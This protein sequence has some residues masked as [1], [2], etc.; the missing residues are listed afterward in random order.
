LTALLAPWT[1]ALAQN[2]ADYPAKPIQF[3]VPYAA[4]GGS[5]LVVRLIAE[6]MAA[7]LKQP[8][9][10]EN[11]AGAGGNIGMAQVAKAPP[12]GYTLVMASVSVTSNPSIYKNLPFDVARDFAP[13]GTM[14]VA[15]VMLVTNAHSPIH[16]FKEL[17]SYAKAHPGQLSFGSSGT[18]SATHLA[19]EMFKSRL[20]LDM[21]HIPY[22]GSGQA[23]ANVVGG[24]LQMLAATPTTVADFIKEG[25]LIPLVTLGAKRYAAFP[26][27][28]AAAEAAPGFDASSWLGIMAPRG[29]PAAIVG[30]LSQALRL[31]LDEESTRRDLGSMGFV[32]D[33]RTPAQ[34]Q[35]LIND[36]IRDWAPVVK[37]AGITAGN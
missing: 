2:A 36:S 37:A 20:G 19:V 15:P 5:D 29:T 6:K 16:D 24:Q 35:A 7:R 33:F 34:M 1:G 21:V 3:I 11:R 13:V 22:K 27:V 8:F 31:S 9:V 18:G 26:D 14:A 10:I 17:I 28:P 32:P 4:G 12:D 25:R 30:K 23:I